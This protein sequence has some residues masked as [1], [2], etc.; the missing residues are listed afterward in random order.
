[1]LGLLTLLSHRYPALIPFE[2]V[3]DNCHLGFIY[4]RQCVNYF[5]C[6]KPHS[7]TIK[8]VFTP[9]CRLTQKAGIG[10]R[11]LNLCS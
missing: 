5:S 7:T 8:L 1:M 11:T 3:G 9:F 10:C 4:G 2:K 6:I